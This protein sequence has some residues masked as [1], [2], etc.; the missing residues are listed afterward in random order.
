SS[1]FYV[2]TKGEFDKAIPVTEFQTFIICTPAKFDQLGLSTD[3]VGRPVKYMGRSNAPTQLT[4]DINIIRIQVIPYPYFR[5]YR[6]SAFVTGRSCN[7]R[8]F[9]NNTR[10]QMLSCSVYYTGSCSTQVLTYFFNFSVS[11]QNICILKNSFFFI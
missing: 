5:S 3:S 7:V 2:F 8:V 6:L 10:C 9:I 11:Y 1:S 4:I